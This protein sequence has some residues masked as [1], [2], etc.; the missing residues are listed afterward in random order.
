MSSTLKF[1]PIEK[2]MEKGKN[3]ELAKSLNSLV[4]GFNREI[5][6]FHKK[7]ENKDDGEIVHKAC[8]LTR[9]G[10]LMNENRYRENKAV[11]FSNLDLQFFGLLMNTSD[12]SQWFIAVH[13]LS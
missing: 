4:R 5:A 12:Y 11:R 6:D 7:I 1:S 13:L 3:N 10:N 2:L 9:I 8:S